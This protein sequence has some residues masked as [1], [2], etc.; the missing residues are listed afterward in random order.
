MCHEAGVDERTTRAWALFFIALHD[1]GKVDVRFQLKVPE[2]LAILQ[3]DFDTEMAEPEYG[4]H[5]GMGGYYWFTK[6]MHSLGFTDLQ[7]DRWLPWIQAVA[8][9]HGGLDP[10][11]RVGEPD[12]DEV[13]IA[14]DQLARRDWMEALAELF[15][16]PVGLSLEDLPPPCPELVAGFCSV[17][18]WLGSN[19]DYFDYRAD[20]ISL[21]EYWDHAQ[22]DAK[23][24]FFDSGLFQDSLPKGGMKPL[25]PSCSRANFRLWWI[26]CR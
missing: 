3:P 19:E 6:D 4:Y 15:L 20:R 16:N 2:V 24:A 11:E 25:F 13:V 1:L 8:G 23:K 14:M 9:H 7:W 18:D 5:H 21:P 22:E 12:A 26:N 17:S 10:H